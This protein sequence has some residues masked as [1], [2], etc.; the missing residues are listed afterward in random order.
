MRSRTVLLTSTSP[1]AGEAADARADVDR[2]AAD[3][4]VGEQFAFAGV[5]SGADLQVEVADAGRG[6][7]SR[8]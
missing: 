2:E 6:S 4:V 8:C 7:R 1:G 5:Q 3:V